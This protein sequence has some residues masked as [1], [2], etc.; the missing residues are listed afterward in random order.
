MDGPSGATGTANLR[1]ISESC[2]GRTGNTDLIAQR[3][4]PQV[5]YR[6]DTA[7]IT[8][9]S[10][11]RDDQGM[12]RLWGT[13]SKP[14]VLVYQNN[15][16]SLRKELVPEQTLMDPDYLKG[17]SDQVLTNE[18]PPEPITSENASEYAVGHTNDVIFDDGHQRVAI[19]VTD[20]KTA[21]EIESGERDELSV[22]YEVQASRADALPGEVLDKVREQFGNIDLVQIKRKANHVAATEDARADV[23]FHTDSDDVGWQVRRDDTPD[24]PANLP[25]ADV[26]AQWDGDKAEQELQQFYDFDPASDDTPEAYADNFAAYPPMNSDLFNNVSEFWGPFVRVIGGERKIVPDGVVALQSAVQGSRSEPDLP[27][28]TDKGGVRNVIEALWDKVWNKHGE[29]ALPAPNPIWKRDDSR[30]QQDSNQ[31]QPNEGTMPANDNFRQDQEGE[32]E[33]AEGGQ[34]TTFQEFLPQEVEDMP[35]PEDLQLSELRDTMDRLAKIK[36]AVGAKRNQ[37]VKQVEEM[38]GLKVDDKE[39]DGDDEPTPSGG[40][41]QGDAMQGG[42]GEGRG[43]ESNMNK[44]SAD[45]VQVTQGYIAEMREVEEVADKYGIEPRRDAMNHDVKKQIAE[46]YT[47][48]RLDDAG[49]DVIDAHY[50]AAKQNA[51]KRQT[52]KAERAASNSVRQDSGGDDDASQMT[53]EEAQRKYREQKVNASK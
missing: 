41:E 10:L 34:G 53:E 11:E 25:V 39:R 36:K 14:G 50:K 30:I 4:C 5:P 52:R 49:K 19:T 51:G 40:P 45:V 31:S 24:N 26:T 1:P 33:Q 9:S 29:E 35:S 3:D 20:E 37:F 12:L 28:S 13:V 15:D 23:G 42:M 44:D 2:L 18:H 27:P 6:Y 8:S 16:G 38:T 46:E 48:Q 21:Q 47:G 7:K 43:D 32:G 17:L 22:G